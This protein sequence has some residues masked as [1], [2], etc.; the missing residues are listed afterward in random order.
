MTTALL[1]VSPEKSQDHPKQKTEVLTQ[2]PSWS[3]TLGKAA[4]QLGWAPQY[5]AI[6][7]QF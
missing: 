4:A 3:G 2:T 5:P 6:K 7:L 1:E